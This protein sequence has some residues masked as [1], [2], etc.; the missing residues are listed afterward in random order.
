MGFGLPCK[1]GDRQRS[2]FARAAAHSPLAPEAQAAYTFP[3]HET[4]IISTRF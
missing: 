3:R 4:G 2:V 1:G